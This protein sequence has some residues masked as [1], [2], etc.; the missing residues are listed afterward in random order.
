MM[1]APY[2][3]VSVTESECMHRGAPRCLITVKRIGIAG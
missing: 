3:S 2:Q 1:R